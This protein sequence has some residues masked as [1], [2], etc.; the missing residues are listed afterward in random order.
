MPEP[1]IPAA[2]LYGPGDLR[3]ETVPH[4]GDPPPGHVL[5]RV[6]VVGVCG[7]DLH[8]YRHAPSVENGPATPLI[9]GHEFAGVVQGV[10]AG[11]VDGE[12]RPLRIGTRVAVDPAHSCGKCEWCKRGDPNLCPHI[13]FF[14]LAPNDG[15]LRTFLHAPA[16]DCFPVPAE[17]DATTA[18]LLEPLGVALHTLDLAKLRLGESVAVVGAGPI[19]LCVLRLLTAGWAGSVLAAD[20]LSWRAERAVQYGATAAFCNEST[21]IVA[22][23]LNATDQRGVDVAIEVATGGE[24]LQQAAEMLAPGGRLIAVGIDSDD[25]FQLRHSTARRKGLTIR[26]VRRMKHA[27]PRA[28]RLVQ[29]SDVPW[30]DLVSHRFPLD[31]VADAFELNADYQDE[32]I[33]VMI[34]VNG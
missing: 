2:R 8:A 25:R 12:G 33:K 10:G 3:V 26:M 24:A 4:P 1:Q 22:E 11:A 29:R 14:G 7:S 30:G 23:V 18:T 34:D 21:D 32:V 20:R 27:Y 5:L 17:M 19:G 9:L 15:A 28:I 13:D 31:R 16:E 6:E